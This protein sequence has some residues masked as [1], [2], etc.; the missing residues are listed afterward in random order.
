MVG[1][2]AVRIHAFPYFLPWI[3]FANL[4]LSGNLLWSV[5]LRNPAVGGMTKNLIVSPFTGDSSSR[6]RVTQNDTGSFPDGHSLLTIRAGRAIMNH[7]ELTVFFDY[8]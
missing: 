7:R 1:I 4:N 5:I 3:V 8:L 6:L 2:T